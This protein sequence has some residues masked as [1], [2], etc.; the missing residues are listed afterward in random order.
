VGESAQ[1]ESSS[2]SGPVIAFVRSILK[3][4][5]AAAPGDVIN[6]DADASQIHVAGNEKP[7]HTVM[8]AVTMDGRKLPLSVVVKGKTTRSKKGLDLDKEGLHRS[9]HSLTG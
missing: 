3:P 1:E 6:C 7:S 2:R 5:R 8:A 4:V 9:A